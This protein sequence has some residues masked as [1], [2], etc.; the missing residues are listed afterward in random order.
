MKWGL[1]SV[2]LLFS[3]AAGAWT[4]TVSGHLMSAPDD[5]SWWKGLALAGGVLF[6]LVTAISV[7]VQKGLFVARCACGAGQTCDLHQKK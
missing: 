5:R 1:L 2:V 7:M 6:A 3:L 4:L